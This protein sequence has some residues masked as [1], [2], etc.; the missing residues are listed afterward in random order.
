M[1]SNTQNFRVKYGLD[2]NESAT[3]GSSVTVT[4]TANFGN[5][6]T[7]AGDLVVTGNTQ[8][9]NQTTLQLGTGDILLAANATGAP[10][11]NAS[12]TVNR[13]SAANA[14]LRWNE[15]TD[16]WEFTNDG[17]YFFP[18]RTFA[19]LTLQFSS[20]NSTN[21]NP[22]S[23][24]V[25][26]NNGITS[27][28]TEISISSFE[29]GGSDI[30]MFIDSLDD[31]NSS[32]PAYLL[33]RSSTDSSKLITFSLSSITANTEYRRLSVSY[34][35]GGSVF[36][37]G[38]IIFFSVQRLGDKGEKG[39]KGERITSTSFTDA[40]NTATFTNSDNSTF[41][42]SGI[43]GQKGQKGEII[44]SAVFTD[45]N[46]T[47][48]FTNSDSTTFQVTGVKGQKGAQGFQGVLGAK[49]DTGS[50]GAQG[51]Q[52]FIGVQGS[53]GFQGR[54]GFQGVTGAGGAQ[55]PVGSQGLRGFQGDRGFTGTTGPPGPG[56]QLL[57]SFDIS[58][59]NSY[60]N[61]E[62]DSGLVVGYGYQAG[63]TY[64]GMFLSMNTNG[65]YWALCNSLQNNSVYF[66]WILGERMYHRSNAGGNGTCNF[67]YIQD[68]IVV[69]LEFRSSGMTSQTN[70]TTNVKVHY[71]S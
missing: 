18:L 5:N 41:T 57:G 3:F 55:G 10:S 4:N 16:I 33:F 54:Q 46:N 67:S 24:L 69:W 56:V 21:V 51:I 35:S 52:G 22:G 71:L 53:Q 43:K 63:S 70:L 40:N 50:Q 17:N 27:Q 62:Y 49:G 2:V 39:Q 66:G 14:V 26:F 9:V 13:G 6:V 1:S 37:D 20:L 65:T 45:A 29:Y 12:I 31:G 48:T 59:N 34:I 68:T 15:T 47:T 64:K 25:R 7:I 28:V 61:T 19:D 36:S 38:D 60:N 58:H 30:E 8:F 42:L 23:G 32:P 44:S 11:T